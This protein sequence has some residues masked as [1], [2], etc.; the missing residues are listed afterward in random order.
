MM[1]LTVDVNPLSL[2]GNDRK[3]FYDIVDKLTDST[4]EH[5]PT[6]PART[7]TKTALLEKGRRANRPG[8]VAGLREH[9]N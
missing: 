6:Q 9:Y 8:T 3:F 4:D 7:Q 5:A 1:R 2:R